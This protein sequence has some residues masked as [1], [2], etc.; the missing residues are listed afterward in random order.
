MSFAKHY[1]IQ[2]FKNEFMKDL[3]K[4]KLSK[5]TYNNIIKN[6]KGIDFSKF[7]TR[8]E[9]EDFIKN[10]AIDFLSKYNTI[11]NLNQALFYSKTP[12]F[13]YVVWELESYIKSGFPS[14]QT[15]QRKY[16]YEYFVGDLNRYFM[17]MYFKSDFNYFKPLIN[18]AMT[19]QRTM[20]KQALY[21]YY[22]SS[23]TFNNITFDDFMKIYNKI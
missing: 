10:A 1:K 7:S 2:I 8:K 20:E 16:Y 15:L 3:Y 5:E 12:S 6:Y 9:K 4:Y 11:P 22:L 13:N 17:T 21:A 18:R 14:Y 23:I 19:E